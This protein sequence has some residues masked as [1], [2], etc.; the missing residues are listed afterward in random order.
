MIFQSLIEVCRLSKLVIFARDQENLRTAMTVEDVSREESSGTNDQ[1]S[2]FWP[3]EGSSTR[4][5]S[6]E[7]G[8]C[9]HNLIHRFGKP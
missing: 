1:E 3:C 5:W 7:R 9:G 8:G 4:S 6:R 2:S